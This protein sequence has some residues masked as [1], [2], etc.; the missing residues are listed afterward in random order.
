MSEMVRNAIDG[1]G[2]LATRHG[3][4]RDIS[5]SHDNGDGSGQMWEVVASRLSGRADGMCRCLWARAV[6]SIGFLYGQR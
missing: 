2:G 6:P 3:P 1:D 5:H 4:R